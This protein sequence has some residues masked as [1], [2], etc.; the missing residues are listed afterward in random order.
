[1]GKNTVTAA[2][3][4]SY[5]ELQEW[6][7]ALETASRFSRA[8]VE[9]ITYPKPRVSIPSTRAHPMWI[10]ATRQRV[11]DLIQ[12]EENWDSRGSAEVKHDALEFAWSLLSQ[13]MPPTASAPAIVP[14]GHGGVQLLWH[15][16]IGDLEIEVVRPNDVV[17]YY[18]DKTDGEEREFPLTT[19]FGE[20][21]KILWSSFASA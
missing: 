12:L 21:S 1:M 2:L 7:A 11:M 16:S 10:A 15:N 18:L 9:R 14:L 3:K 5:D 4:R 8:T 13:S 17:V 20:I 6:P 19:D